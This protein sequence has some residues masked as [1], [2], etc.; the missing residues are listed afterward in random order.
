M[1]ALKRH[2][3][4]TPPDLFQYRFPEDRF[5]VTAY[6]Y[7]SWIAQIKKHAVDNEYPIPT[8]E[9]CENQLCR[10]LSGEWC[11]GGGPHSFVNTR[12]TLNDFIRGTKVLT[13]FV[14]QGSVV[15]KE[16][17]ESRALIC[18]RC[19][20]NVRVPGCASCSQ[21]ANVV[22]EIKGAQNTKYDNLLEACGICHCSNQAQVW[23]PAEYLAK[24][25]TPEMMETYREIDECWKGKAIDSMQDVA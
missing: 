12:F 17:A 23:I 7:D 5:L 3:G 25:V 13:P 9:E 2:D 24:G 4:P 21:M 16:V 22:G 20:I 1:L 8:N 6:D 15:S 10:R 18:S 11:I 14:L 19:P